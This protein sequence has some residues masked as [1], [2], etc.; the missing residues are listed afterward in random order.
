MCLRSA[1]VRQAVELVSR[2]LQTVPAMTLSGK[3]RYDAIIIGAGIAGLVSGCYL[4]KAGMKVLIAEQHSQPGGYCTSFQRNGFLFDAAA[5]SFGGYRKNGIMHKVLQE[6]GV[7]NRITI[8]KYDPSDIVLAPDHRLHFY[9]DM[10]KTIRGFQEAFEHE[11]KGLNDFFLFL[12]NSSPL[13]LVALRNKNFQELL[14]RFFR[15]E[16][17]KAILAFPVLGNGGLPPSRMSAFTAI[18]I[19]TEFLLDG[20]YYPEQSMQ[21]LSD[22]LADTFKMHGG[23]L[24]TSCR[25]AQIVA[26]ES[27]VTGVVFDKVG[28]L[29]ADCVI[30]GCDARQTFL[31]LLQPGKV[32]QA[33]IRTLETW[34]PSLSVFV[35][36]LG[37]DRSFEGLPSPG[38]NVWLLPHYDIENMYE[39]IR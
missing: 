1:T 10:G 17:L 38:V 21:S 11:S 35:V 19:Y 2:L 23:E 14:D 34:E 39:M 3:D 8:R 5:H 31:T 9:S 28:L 25:A 24:R 16:K 15:D 12:S 7:S 20:G 37:L 26:D 4:A 29:Q 27:V 6:L 30:S 33:F 36:Y 13:D 32:N 22:A 18:K